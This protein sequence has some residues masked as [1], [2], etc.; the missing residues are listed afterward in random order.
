MSIPIGNTILTP[1]QQQVASFQI[2]IAAQYAQL[3]LLLAV[4]T[5]LV[6]NNPNATPQQVCDALGTGAANLFA[7]SALLCDLLGG[8][9]G[10]TPN[11]VPAG[12]TVTA[13]D[14][15]TITLT[16]PTS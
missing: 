9:T 4:G 8:I 2:R 15:G 16:A 11:P 5:N 7:L 6:W 13:N 1:L 12:W 3:Q 14:D 10:T